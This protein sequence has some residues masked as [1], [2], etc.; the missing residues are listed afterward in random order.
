MTKGFVFRGSVTAIEKRVRAFTIV[1]FLFRLVSGFLS[2]G[3]LHKHKD[4]IDHQ[5]TL[6]ISFLIYFYL[7]EC[8]WLG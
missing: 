7:C 8:V 6:K 4:H 1:T 3:A 2:V 5:T